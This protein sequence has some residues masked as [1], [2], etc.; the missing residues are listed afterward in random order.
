[1][2]FVSTLGATIHCKAYS[3]LEVVPTKDEIL[4]SEFSAEMTA[5]ENANITLTGLNPNTQYNIFSYAEGNGIA[6]NNT[7]ADLKVT[8]TTQAAAGM[9]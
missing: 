2:V 9:F 3:D 6:M 7:I 5:N 8:V 1:M 4:E